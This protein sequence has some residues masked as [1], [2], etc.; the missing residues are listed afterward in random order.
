MDKY[1][2][3]ILE[4]MGAGPF[5]EKGKDGAAIYEMVFDPEKPDAQ[6]V[7]WQKVTKGIGSWSINL[8]MMF[9]G[10]DHCAAYLRTRVWSPEDQDAQLEMGSDDAVK[11]WLNGKL[12][13]SQWT[14]NS[15][16]PRQHLAAVHLNKGWNELLLKVVD[17]AGGWEVGCRLRAKDGTALEGLKFSTE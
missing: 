13:F 5:T 16:A 3:H 2:G 15:P 14:Q 17:F 10:L 4:W 11:A 1:E 6:N 7:K 8:E 9:G 12:A